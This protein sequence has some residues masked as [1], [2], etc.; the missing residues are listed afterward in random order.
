MEAST[1]TKPGFQ[2]PLA[3]LVV[4]SSPDGSVPQ[5]LECIRSD[6]VELVEKEDIS[7]QS[8]LQIMRIFHDMETLLG[9]ECVKRDRQITNLTFDLEK[10]KAPITPMPPTDTTRRKRW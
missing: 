3:A 2:W 5:R 1:S 8:A 9:A 6:C 10:T 4:P 7:K